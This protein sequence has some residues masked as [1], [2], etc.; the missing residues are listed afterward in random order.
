MSVT[1]AGKIERT[2]CADAG[3]EINLMPPNFFASLLEKKSDMVV[4]E[5]DEPR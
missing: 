4:R 5:F 2:M 1:L 3:P